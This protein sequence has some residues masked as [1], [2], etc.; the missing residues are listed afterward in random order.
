MGW[1]N[2]DYE[3]YRIAKEQMQSENNEYKQENLANQVD[4]TLSDAWRELLGLSNE[5][6]AS[7]DAQPLH[8][9]ANPCGS[10][11]AESDP[12]PEVGAEIPTLTNDPWAALQHGQ[13]IEI[14]D[15]QQVH[16]QAL[17]DLDLEQALQ[18][19]QEHP[20]PGSQEK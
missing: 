19:M 16:M 9:R 1:L 18:F 14:V 17:D 2:T 10:P 11:G 8:S 4:P 5:A 7:T 15:L 12:Q 13:G 3:K 20:T 6:T